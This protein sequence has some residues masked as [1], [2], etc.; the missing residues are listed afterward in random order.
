MS[1]DAL[2]PLIQLGFAAVMAFLIWRG[3]ETMTGTM[4]TVIRDNTIAMTELKAVIGEHAR[5]T[6]RLGVVIDQLD[7]RVGRLEVEVEIGRKSI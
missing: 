6:E 5:S 2:T 1:L 3:Y 7:K 4:I